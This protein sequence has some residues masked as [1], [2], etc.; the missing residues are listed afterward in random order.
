MRF[1]VASPELENVSGNSRTGRRLT[2][3]TESLNLL[4]IETGD[5]VPLELLPS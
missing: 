5:G 3:P 2:R 1:R 4:L